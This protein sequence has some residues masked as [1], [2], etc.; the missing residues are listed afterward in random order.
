MLLNK[1][2]NIRVSYMQYRHRSFFPGSRSS[3]RYPIPIL[4]ITVSTTYSYLYIVKL[5][6]YTK[7][8][9]TLLFFP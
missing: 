3:I 2:N 5:K 4:T 7:I 6:S 1:Y 9:N 8:V